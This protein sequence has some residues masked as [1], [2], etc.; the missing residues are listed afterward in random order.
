MRNSLKLYAATMSAAVLAVSGCSSHSADEEATATPAASE[1]ASDM[2]PAGDAVATES[3]AAASTASA[4]ATPE[5]KPSATLSAK[6]T[7]V[8]TAKPVPVAVVT[9]PA[10][11]ARCAVCHNAEKGAGAKIGPNLWGVYGTKAGDI[12]GFTFTDALKNSGLTWNEATLDQWISGPMKMVPGTSMGFPGIKDPAKRAEIV[13][14][15]KQAR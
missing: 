7:P 5:A 13:A 3:P 9:P 11:F 2:A 8:A 6:S 12:A 14:F 15:L 1:T 10:A 4:S